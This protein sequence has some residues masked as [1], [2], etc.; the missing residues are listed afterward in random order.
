[1]CVCVC[2]CVCEKFYDNVIGTIAPLPSSK[3]RWD[4]VVSTFH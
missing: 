1:M 4:Y 2:V 3:Q